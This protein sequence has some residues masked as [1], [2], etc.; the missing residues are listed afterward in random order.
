MNIEEAKIKLAESIV[1]YIFGDT[2][3]LKI[4]LDEFEDAVRADER[5]QFFVPF[6]YKS[7]D[8]K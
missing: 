1:D 7:G 6:P 4:A 5:S 8:Q 2:Q 3:N